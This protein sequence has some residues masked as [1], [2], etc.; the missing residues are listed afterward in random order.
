MPQGV[1][2]F[3]Y[4]EEKHDSGMTGIAGLPV[5]LDLI[6]AMGLSEL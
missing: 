3:N 1:L 5:Y 6:H 4:T 2:G